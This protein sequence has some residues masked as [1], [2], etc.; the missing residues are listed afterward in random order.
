MKSKMRSF[1]ILVMILVTFVLPLNAFAMDLQYGARTPEA[2]VEKYFRGQLY[3]DA[4]MT[5]N[6]SNMSD[7]YMDYF[8]SVVNEDKL[9][10]LSNFMPDEE[11]SSATED[12]LRQFYYERDCLVQFYEEL[13][14]S[15]RRAYQE[16]DI[17]VEFV[18]LG[19]VEADRADYAEEFV[20]GFQQCGLPITQ[21][22]VA[23]VNVTVIP[24]GRVYTQQA[25]VMEVGGVWYVQDTLCWHYNVE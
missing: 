25:A 15:G 4:E 6:A 3:L 23:E 2:A 12:Y 22:L 8:R 14:N 10:E 9:A 20:A 5:I 7:G 24:E 21:I 17:L 16:D 11:C 13:R 1:I 18:F 19:P